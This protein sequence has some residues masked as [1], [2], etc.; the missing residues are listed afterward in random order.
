MGWSWRSGVWPKSGINA[1]PLPL[2]FGEGQ[3]REDA[4]SG[5]EAYRFGVPLRGY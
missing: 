5:F 4:S 2:R 1:V 3:L